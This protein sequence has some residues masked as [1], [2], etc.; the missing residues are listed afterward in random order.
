M[1]HT[2]ITRLSMFP[3]CTASLLSYLFIFFHF[4]RFSISLFFL[5][6]FFLFSVIS[7]FFFTQSS[8]FL[9]SICISS[10]NTFPSFF[11]RSVLSSLPQLFRYSHS[12]NLHCSP[13]YP[14]YLSSLSSLQVVSHLSLPAVFLCFLSPPFLSF[15]TCP[16]L[17]IRN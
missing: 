2:A 7:T 14:S 1:S 12:L 13:F 5:V 17:P 10:L 4:T 8:T 15:M 3:F 9:C 11:F 16:S 6:C